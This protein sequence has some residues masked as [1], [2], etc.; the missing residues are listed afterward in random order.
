MAAETPC[1]P[2]DA[3]DRAVPALAPSGLT[4]S[5]Y[6]ESLLPMSA[7]TGPLRA[8]GDAVRCFART[9]VGALIAA[10]QISVRY[11]FS[12]DWRHIMELSVAPGPERD[13]AQTARDSVARAPAASQPAGGG[14]IMQLAAFKFVSYADDA[15][16]VQLVRATDGGVHLVSALYT[17]K[18]IAGDWRLQVQASGAQASMV[19]TESS[20]SGFTPWPAG[21]SR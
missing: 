3:K 9:P 1:P 16:V 17:V 11:S 10:A 4:W 21:G 19:Q 15:A 14:T 12:E 20:L 8:D 6:H 18:W 13:A 2:L 5:L 7:T